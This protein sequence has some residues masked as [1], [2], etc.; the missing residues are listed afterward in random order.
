MVHGKDAGWWCMPC[1]VSQ[2]LLAEIGWRLFFTKWSFMPRYFLT[3][4]ISA[5][6]EPVDCEQCMRDKKPVRILAHQ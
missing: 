2:G 3:F 1:A 4:D 5:E 6:V